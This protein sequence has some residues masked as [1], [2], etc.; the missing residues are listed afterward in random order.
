MNITMQASTPEQARQEILRVLENMRRSYNRSAERAI[1]KR[2]EAEALSS[3][4]ALAAAI[5]II[6]EIRIVPKKELEQ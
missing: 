2:V 3:A 1:L 4:Q 6:S 5:N